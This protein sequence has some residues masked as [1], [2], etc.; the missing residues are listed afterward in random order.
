MTRG[1]LESLRREAVR[2]K[3]T[4]NM[5]HWEGESVELMEKSKQAHFTF[6]GKIKIKKKKVFVELKLSGLKKEI[7][8]KLSCTFIICIKRT[9]HSLVCKTKQLLHK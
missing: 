9:E 5:L 6:W 1:L 2:E 7:L 4:I 3:S 8:H